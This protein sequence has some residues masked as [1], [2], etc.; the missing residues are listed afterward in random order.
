MGCELAVYSKKE[1]MILRENTDTLTDRKK[2]LVRI[3]MP[4]LPL[5]TLQL[6]F[7]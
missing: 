5:E 3:T 7:T 2:D 6:L 4:I 1:D